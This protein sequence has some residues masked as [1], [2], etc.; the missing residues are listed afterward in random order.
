MCP[1]PYYRGLILGCWEL[2]SCSV[3]GRSEENDVEGNGVG[4]IL[5]PPF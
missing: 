4:C 1:L 5:A 2:A 3:L